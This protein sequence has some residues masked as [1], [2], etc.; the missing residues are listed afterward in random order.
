MYPPPPTHSPADADNATRGT[1][2]DAAH[3]RLSAVRLG[4]LTDPY[5]LPLV[6]RAR[7]VPAR[8]PLMNVG[9]YVRA[10]AIDMLVEGW[11]DLMGEEEEGVQVVCLGAGSDTRFWRLMVGMKSSFSIN[12]DLGN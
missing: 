8:A 12:Y 10:T 11:L 3:S 2:T 5:L 7:L 6:P 9:T 4:Y 1:D